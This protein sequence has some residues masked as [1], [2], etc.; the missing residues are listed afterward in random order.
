MM[1][2]MQP[3]KWSVLFVV[4]LVSFI[5]NLDATIVVTG[6]PQLMRD[7]RLSIDTGMW[8]IT[9]FYIT[10]TVFLLPSGRWSDMYGTKRIFLWGFALFTL[11]TALCGMAG[12][13]EALI[14]ARLLQGSGAAMAMAASTPI[15]LRTFP[16]NE[17]GVALGINNM[18]WVTGSLIG[19][20]VGGALIG[21]FG[22]R[23]MFYSVVPIGVIGL[24][25]GI[26][27][28]RDS[29]E[30]EKAKTDWPGMLT[31]STGLTTLLIALSEGQAWG[32]ASGRTLGLF[33]TAVVL[34]IAFILIEIK[35][36]YPLFH[37]NL[38]AYRNYSIGLGITM[39]YCIGY[40]AVTILLT[41]YLQGVHN[42]SPLESGIMLIPLSV[43]QLFIAPFGGRLADRF[44]P[45]RMILL[46]SLLIGLA[47][48]ML[49][50][51]G[52]Q[53][54]NM[55]V[56][57]PL[58]II[59]AAT[60]LSWPSLAKAVLS[61]APQEQAGSASGMFWTVYNMC[62]AIS[63]ALALAVVQ[64]VVKS[65]VASQLFSGAVVE[66][67]GNTKDALIH[68]LNIGFR[69]FAVF[70]AL[71]VMLGLFLLRPQQKTESVHELRK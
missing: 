48:L 23:S 29:F 38:L 34:W 70:L 5:T 40:F 16:P 59:S 30:G 31:F 68:A 4:T 62:R 71:A 56:I 13:G 65:D 10:S 15:L 53:L 55:A 25:A 57:I 1:K 43:P 60:G 67:L 9:S 21:E 32:W 14:M 37:L 27:F 63:Q 66:E 64:L 41:L 58:I 36:R 24:A 50:Q 45:A 20:V 17:L 47:L 7:L 51:L 18:A 61:A 49:G 46:G 22:W 44:G 52:T 54:S 8:T 3:G 39:S 6:L 28:L 12:S 11:A 33:A 42:L 2:I 19:P 26:L 69:F 35:A